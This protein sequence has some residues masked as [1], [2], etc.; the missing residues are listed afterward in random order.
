MD[1]AVSTQQMNIESDAHYNLEWRESYNS[2]QNTIFVIV[3]SVFNYGIAEISEMSQ[4]YGYTF[5]DFT[6]IE[7]EI[8]LSVVTSG[9]AH[10]K[11]AAEVNM[12]IEIAARSIHENMAASNI[13]KWIIV[14]ATPLSIFPSQHK[15]ILPASPGYIES[16]LYAN[17]K[18]K[19]VRRNFNASKYMRIDPR[20]LRYCMWCYAE[21]FHGDSDQLREIERDCALYARDHTMLNSGL[22]QLQYLLQAISQNTQN[23]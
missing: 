13:S 21:I 17:P 5:F 10:E 22:S 16:I 1:P 14:T 2:T 6:E 23:I 8:G 7:R 20:R 11:I 12:Q 15:Y 4:K 18:N 9:I 3:Y 19:Y